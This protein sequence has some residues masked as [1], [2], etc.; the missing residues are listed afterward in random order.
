MHAGELVSRFWNLAQ[1]QTAGF[2]F[3]PDCELLLRGFIQQGVG[4]MV[5][6]GA[7]GDEH[8]IHQAESNLSRF[9]DEMTREAMRMG[10]RELHEPTF[11][12][13][14]GLCPLWPFC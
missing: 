3:A 1:A 14:R 10:L 7:A 5:A 6:E 4:R 8:K 12:A 9:I 11:G 2:G 13:A